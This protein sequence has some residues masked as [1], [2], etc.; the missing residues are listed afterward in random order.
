MRDRWVFLQFVPYLL[1]SV[2]D[3]G[4]GRVPFADRKLPSLGYAVVKNHGV[5][6]K[7]IERIFGHGEAFFALDEEKKMEVSSLGSLVL[8]L[9]WKDRVGERDRWVVIEAE[10]TRLCVCCM[11]V[12]QLI[13]TQSN[14]F[15]GF[16]P[17]MH[18]NVELVGIPRFCMPVC[19]PCL[20]CSLQDGLGV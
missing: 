2:Y 10:L 11:T 18:E 16:Q 7:M 6:E 1:R 15:K 19:L 20:P 17:S 4:N 8:M 13:N 12:D 14:N 5:D 3:K 9:C